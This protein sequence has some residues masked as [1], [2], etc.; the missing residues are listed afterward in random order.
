MSTHKRGFHS[1]I[2]SNFKPKA[3]YMT[4][5]IGTKNYLTGGYVLKYGA[6]LS[7]RPNLGIFP[8]GVTLVK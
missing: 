2:K 8:F 6:F 4:D 7:S 5:V 3:A 1:S